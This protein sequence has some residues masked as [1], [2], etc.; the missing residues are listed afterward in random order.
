MKISEK[1]MGDCEG[2]CVERGRRSVGEAHRESAIMG[3]GGSKRLCGGMCI[4]WWRSIHVGVLEERRSDVGGRS[5]CNNGGWIKHR[6]RERMDGRIGG[7][8]RGNEL[9]E[10]I[11]WRGGGQEEW[12]GMRI[13][14]E[15]M[16][17]EGRLEQ[18]NVVDGRQS[19]ASSVW[20]DGCIISWCAGCGCMGRVKQVKRDLGVCDGDGMDCWKVE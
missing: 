18:S 4:G 11:G 1:T 2:M 9:S 5:E 17:K 3:S 12:Q 13:G 20:R 16:S 19:G 15:A 14:N 8:I 7:M 10:C 6:L